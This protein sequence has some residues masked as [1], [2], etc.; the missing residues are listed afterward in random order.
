MGRE[1]VSA[2]SQTTADS[3]QGSLSQST[4]TTQQAPS[5]PQA[6]VKANATSSGTS[7]LQKQI[8]EMQKQIEALKVSF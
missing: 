4:K 7:A 2:M 1:K 5:Q 8:A 3:N 6:T